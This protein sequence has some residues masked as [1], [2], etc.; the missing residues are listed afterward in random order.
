MDD[1]NDGRESGTTIQAFLCVSLI[2]LRL[3]LGW[4]SITLTRQV[5][6]S[7]REVILIFLKKHNKIVQF[8]SN[9]R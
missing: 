2:E 7:A 6:I 9:T 4:I 1:S 8:I 3:S 5:D